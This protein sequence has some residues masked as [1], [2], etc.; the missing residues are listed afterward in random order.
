MP[1][2]IAT[3]YNQSMTEWMKE[4]IVLVEAEFHSKRIVGS[5]ATVE[6]DGTPRSRM[7]IVRSFN[8]SD[9]TL[10]ITTDSRSDKMPQLEKQPSA[11]LVFWLLNERQQFRLRGLVR[12]VRN[13]SARQELWNG[14]ND[15]SRAMF[16]WPMPGAVRVAGSEFVKAVAPGP[17]PKEF[18]LLVL[19]PEVVEALELNESPHRRRRWSEAGGWR[20]ELLNP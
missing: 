8:E 13:G 3:R 11:E 5:L 16:F 2:D 6:T 9:N 7:V 19:K 20:M 4:L 17:A 14:L 1:A 18:V 12:I 15:S 10:W